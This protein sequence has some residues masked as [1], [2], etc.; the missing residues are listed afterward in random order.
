MDSRNCSPAQVAM[1]E[2]C[3][4][5]VDHP[6]RIG[7][8]QKI[9]G[10]EIAVADDRVGHLQQRHDLLGALK[11]LRQ[12]PA[13]ALRDE[14]PGQLQ[15]LV[16]QRPAG[17]GPRPLR[18]G[19]AMQGSL[20]SSQPPGKARDERRCGRHRII[21]PGP[22]DTLHH[23]NREVAHFPRCEQLQQRRRGVA[24]RGDPALQTALLFQGRETLGRGGDTGDQR[25][26]P[27]GRKASTG[28]VQ[29]VD[30]K[31]ESACDPHRSLGVDHLAGELPR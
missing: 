1:R 21:H 27:L 15:P 28:K 10:V 26:R 13:Q 3:V 20:G 31:V 30:P 19:Q 29:P 24:V 5:P 14:V 9:A 6:D 23:L 8:Q 7:I 4:G 18:Y 2:S 12:W 25:R 17:S 16:S 22:R 11:C